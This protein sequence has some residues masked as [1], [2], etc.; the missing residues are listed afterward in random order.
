MEMLAMNQRIRSL[1][2]LLFSV[3]LGACG[4]K[5]QPENCTNNI[6]D[7]LDGSIDCSD[8]DCV[9]VSNCQEPPDEIC[10]NGVD[11]DGNGAIDCEDA[12]CVNDP[13]C[14]VDP[15]GNNTIDAGEQCDG[16]NLNGQDCTDFGFTGGTL[17]CNQDCTLSTL[18]CANEVCNDFIDNDLDGQTDCN[19]TDCANAANCQPCGNNT[20]DAGEECDSNNLNG[21]SCQGLG[22]DGGIL[23]CNTDCTIDQSGCADEVC[24]GGLD[25]DGD[26]LVDCADPDCANDF[27]CVPRCGDN[28]INQANEECDNNNLNGQSCQGLGFDA[29]ALDCDNNCQL[30]ITGCV[31]F[32][33]NGTVDNGEDCD[34]GNIGNQSCQTLGFDAG[35]LAC[36]NNT[37]EFDTSG[38]VELCGN[39]VVDAGEQCD[40]NNIG[41]QDCTDFG[42]DGGVLTCNAGCQLTTAQCANENCN[43]NIDNDLDGQV[44]CNDANC[45]NAANCQDCGNGAIDAGEQCDGN[46]LNN[47][48]CQT[49]GFDGGTLSCNNNCFFSLVG[50]A[51]E[52]CNNNLDDDGDGQVDCADSNCTNNAICNEIGECNDN[53]DNDNDNATDCNDSDCANDA[54]CLPFCGDGDI[55]QAG[56]QCEGAD[57][58]GQSC[59]TLGFISGTLSCSV[60]CTFDVSGCVDELCNNGI[61]DDG[62]NAIDCADLSCSNDPL[63]ANGTETTCEDFADN[64]NDG[65]VDCEDNTSCKTLAACTPGN[66]PTGGA[67]NTANQCQANNTDP[68]CINDGDLNIDFPGGYCSQFCNLAANDCGGDGVCVSINLPS[69]NG[70]CFDGCTTD[71]NCR[72]GYSCQ[73]IGNARVCTVEEDCDNGIEDD[74]DGYIDCADADCSGD[75]ACP[76]PTELEPNDISAQADPFTEPFVGGINVPGDQDF[77]AVNTV[78]AGT[79]ITATVVNLDGT[80]CTAPQP[81]TDLQLLDTNGTTQLAFNDDINGQTNFCSQVIATVGAPGTYFLRVRSSAQFQPN[82]IFN[83]RVVVVL[84]EPQL[85]EVEPNN[86][87]ATADPFVSPFNG[88]ITPVGDLDFISVV[89]T[90][91]NTVITAEVGDGGNG[92]CLA[93]AM[94]PEVGIIDRD[95]TT[96]IGFNDDINPNNVNFCSRTSAFAVTPGTYFIRVRASQQF[97]ANTTFDYQLNV[98]LTPTAEVESNNTAALSDPFTDPFFARITPANDIDFIAVT[99]TVAN[100]T[101]TAEVADLENGQCATGALDSLLRIIDRNGTTILIENDDINANANNFCSRASVVATVPGTYFVRVQSFNSATQFNYRLLVTLQ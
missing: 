89:T 95:G 5:P 48:S 36:N 90:V 15:C 23:V 84:D 63:C 17:S 49:Q 27:A 66:T 41:N 71:A 12:A 4:D 77:I 19:D 73:A 43:D 13:S 35:N 61:D 80:A 22:F 30:D 79:T 51:D 99:T 87:A 91:A 88:Q 45:A 40:G 47:Q 39:G 1:L 3:V 69:G 10:F 60:A 42:F 70:L 56:E 29:G 38:C 20:I 64:D 53:L 37:C 32:C 76:T 81:D 100:T 25:D 78:V 44:D 6:D 24:T 62:D 31:I 92:D 26:T 58:D 34:S 101:I 82:D 8:F 11:D 50:C 46:N 86:T 72:A 67:C 74:I 85:S 2:G 75:P 68:F 65:L 33:G 93:L 57:L 97:A 54:A 14:D 18:S 28:Q 96:V 59:Q 52:V 55:N 21:Q 94:D 98:T 9:N 7:D 83:Y 16:N